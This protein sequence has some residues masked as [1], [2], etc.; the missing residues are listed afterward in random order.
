MDTKIIMKVLIP[1]LFA[2]TFFSCS[3]QWFCKRCFGGAKVTTIVKDSL[4]YIPADSV[5]SV[6][7]G[8]PIYVDGDTIPC[9]PVKEPIIIQDKKGGVS[10]TLTPTGD[11][12]GMEV[13]ADCP[14]KMVEVPVY[15]ETKVETGLA[16]WKAIASIIAALIAGAFIMK[17]FG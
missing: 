16:P 3:N 14:E 2:L 12:K 17:L 15:I 5:D 7:V 8:Y 6:L 11:K 10:V 4:I 1:I 9:I 13:K